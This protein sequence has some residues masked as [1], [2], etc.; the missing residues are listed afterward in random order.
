MNIQDILQN[1]LGG[2]A[3]AG[4]QQLPAVP[5]P[6][7]KPLTTAPPMVNPQSVVPDDW[8]N[9]IGDSFAG[10][11]NI[12]P[13]QT[14]M[15]SFAQGFSGAQGARKTR[16]DEE[17]AKADKAAAA[18]SAA[19]QQ[20]F[21]NTLARDESRRAQTR[22]KFGNLKTAADID[23]M[24]RDSSGSLSAKSL[25]DLET[26][27]NDYREVL[28]GKYNQLLVSDNNDNNAIR[29]S[30][31]ELV[32]VERQRQLAQLRQV[33][34]GSGEFDAPQGPQGTEENPHMPTTPEDRE[35]LPNGAIY[36]NPADGQLY[37]KQ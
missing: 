23:K 19:A 16:A 1:L 32:E 3:P 25:A 21:E 9:R 11:G 30:I 28:A 31:E 7:A 27:M 36:I 37:R 34:G 18:R 26:R 15:S 8:K 10:V 14:A 22:D 24:A 2:G 6:R 5:I 4:P 13:G 20:D 33:A 35:R 12:R 17:Q 29:N